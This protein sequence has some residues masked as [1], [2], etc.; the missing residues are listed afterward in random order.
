MFVLIISKGFECR[1]YLVHFKK[2]ERKGF[3]I[4]QNSNPKTR[5]I[6]WF[7]VVLAVAGHIRLSEYP[8]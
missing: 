5:S 1:A 2:P 4:A 8:V 6:E 7:L 3:A